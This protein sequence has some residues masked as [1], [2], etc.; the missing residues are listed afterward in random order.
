MTKPEQRWRPIGIMPAFKF[1][2]SNAAESSRAQAQNMRVALKQP[3]LINRIELA[4]LRLVYQD[5]AVYADMCREQLSRWR[6]EC[7]TQDQAVALDRMDE[8]VDQWIGDTR[9]VID[10][11]N[12]LLRKN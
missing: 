8:I 2:I 7:T 5:T 12:M 11:V 4:R 6:D 3:G 10:A 1:A 9:M